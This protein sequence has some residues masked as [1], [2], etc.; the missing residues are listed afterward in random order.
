MQRRKFISLLC[1]GAVAGP[2]AAR[3]QQ[4]AMPVI[5]WMSGRSPA[6]STHLLEAFRKG[7]HDT[8][9][10][11]GESISIEYRWAQGDYGR[12]P[13]LANLFAEAKLT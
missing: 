12:L 11:E 3:G 7:L 13:E 4:S 5:G 2:I 6:D 9:Y 8:G 10:V 1:G